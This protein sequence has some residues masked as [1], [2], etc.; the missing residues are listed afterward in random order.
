ML[1]QYLR[2][3]VSV[4]TVD[5]RNLVGVLHAADQL[6]NVVLTSCVERVGAPY[7][8]A[9][10]D[11]D[12]DTEGGEGRSIIRGATSGAASSSFSPMEEVQL[13]A[14]MLRGADVVSI[15]V[16]D[17]Y[18]E[19]GTNVKEWRGRDMPPVATTMCKP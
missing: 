2:K 9:D 19:A 17:V 7:D 1:T 5:G 16:I 3:R 6:L 4:V 8:A 15:A 13:G 18:E 12:G 10:V 11:A 14:V